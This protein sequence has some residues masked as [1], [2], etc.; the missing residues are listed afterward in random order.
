MNILC[1]CVSLLLPQHAWECSYSAW[2]KAELWSIW[3]LIILKVWRNW[4][5]MEDWLTVKALVTETS[6]FLY[7]QGKLLTRMGVT[8]LWGLLLWWLF[9]QGWLFW[10]HSQNLGSCWVWL[11]LQ[12]LWF[13]FRAFCKM[14][15]SCSSSFW[16]MLSYF[17]NIQIH[18][19]LPGAQ[20]DWLVNDSCPEGN[21][22]RAEVKK[23]Q[24]SLWVPKEGQCIK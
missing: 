2:W 9:Y 14:E 23:C 17:Q 8:P 12:C 3:N 4:W 13:N 24:L 1:S 15:T 16:F 6:V 7:L 10:I 19:L 22:Q 20:N 21:F 5:P 18:S 11:M